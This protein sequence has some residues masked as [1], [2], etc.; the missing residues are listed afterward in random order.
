MILRKIIKT[1]KQTLT[2][3]LAILIEKMINQVDQHLV[4]LKLKMINQAR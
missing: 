2:L 4:K 1:I 3:T